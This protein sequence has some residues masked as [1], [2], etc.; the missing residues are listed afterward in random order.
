[1]HFKPLHL[2]EY[3][4]DQLNLFQFDELDCLNFRKV[5]GLWKVSENML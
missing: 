5:L 1:M 2:L 3:D 4:I